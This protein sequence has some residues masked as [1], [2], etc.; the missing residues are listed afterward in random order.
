MQISLTTISHLKRSA[1]GLVNGPNHV[2]TPDLVDLIAKLR[3]TVA[4]V[5]CAENKPAAVTEPL[6]ILTVVFLETE[7]LEPELLQRLGRNDLDHLL[8]EYHEQT[9]T[10][11]WRLNRNHR[12]HL[13]P[14]IVLNHHLLRGCLK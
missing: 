7:L 5:I 2:L 1:Y 11:R 4:T 10:P 8:L 13:L 9:N 12:R 6:V 3:W 14:E